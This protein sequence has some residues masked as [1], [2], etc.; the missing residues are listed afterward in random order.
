MIALRK[1]IV[2]A[3]L[4]FALIVLAIS[5]RPL[6]WAIGITPADRHQTAISQTAIWLCTFLLCIFMGWLLARSGKHSL[7]HHAELLVAGLVGA[8][9]GAAALFWRGE[10]DWPVHRLLADIFALPGLWLGILLAEH[11]R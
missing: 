5:V 7:R 10:Y 4:W 11:R 6:L 3:S 1:F 2:S 8:A 9:I